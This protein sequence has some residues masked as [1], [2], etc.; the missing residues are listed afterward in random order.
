MASLTIIDTGFLNITNSGTKATTIVNSGTAIT[1]KTATISFQGAAN[2]DTSEIINTNTIP[3]AGFGSITAERITITGVLDRGV[4]ADMTA[5]VLL[6]DLKKTY[7]VK[8]LYYDSTSDGYRDLS[9]T[10]GDTNKDDIHKTDNFSGTATPH[11]HIRVINF[12]ITE[13]SSSHMRYV[14]ECVTTA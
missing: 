4:S 10:L 14:L 12:Q 5:V 1:L 9:D 3:I 13:T 8:L 2:V 6:N 11:F 7:G